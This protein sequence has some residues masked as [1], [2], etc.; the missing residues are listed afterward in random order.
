[1]TH[2]DMRTQ[3]FF[4]TFLIPYTVFFFKFSMCCRVVATALS[5]HL[6]PASPP[7][8]LLAILPTQASSSTTTILPPTSSTSSSSIQQTTKDIAKQ[9]TKKAID[10]AS[11]NNISPSTTASSASS[12]SSN[13]LPFTNVIARKLALASLGVAILSWADYEV[14]KKKRLTPLPMFYYSS[15]M[16]G[17][18]GNNNNGEMLMRMKSNKNGGNGGENDVMITTRDL[19]NII[20]PPFLPEEVTIEQYDDK[21]DD[22]EEE[23]E[24]ENVKSNNSNDN[25]RSQ[26]ESLSSNNMPFEFTPSTMKQQ[27]HDFYQSTI[28]ILPRPKTFMTVLQSWY[29]V[30]QI[31]KQ[32]EKNIKRQAIMEELIALQK[33]KK[34]R[35]LNNQ[36]HQNK[37]AL[38]SG[39]WY[40]LRNSSLN[41]LKGITTSLSSGS[42]N[43]APLG[44]ALISG[45]SR[46][47]GRAFAVEL[48]RYE[49]PLILI[50]RDEDKLASLAQDIQSAYGV[51]CIIIKADLSKH[52]TAKKIYETTKKAGLHVDILINNAGVCTTKDLVQSR[53]LDIERMMNVNVASTTVLSHLYAKDM[54]EAKRGRI[55]FVS[56][57]VGA[58][59]SGPGVATYAA[60]KAYEKS[61]AQSMGRELEKYGVGVTCLIP[62][63]VKDTSFAIRSNANEALCFKVPFYPVKAQNVASRG[64]RA[65]LHSG[66][67]EVIPGWHNRIFL[68]ILMPVLPP[69]LTSS[70]VALAW[71]PFRLPWSTN[72]YEAQILDNERIIDNA[73]KNQKIQVESNRDRLRTV[74]NNLPPRQLEIEDTKKRKKYFNNCEIDDQDFDDKIR[75]KE[76]ENK[77]DPNGDDEALNEKSVSEDVEEQSF[78]DLQDI[79]TKKDDQNV[80]DSSQQH[81]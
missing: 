41:S 9:L 40:N 18:N 69:R 4:I 81:Q 54:K 11:N 25:L 2:T 73:G 6:P 7:I 75:L 46:G 42:R 80:T 63:A 8:L 36:K 74:F 19:K 79:E 13:L 76:T 23:E 29:K 24:E 53:E 67:G 39:S 38:S 34:Q 66:D 16:N 28:P 43:V 33:I 15:L 44:Y 20:L 48:A 78:S 47:I 56:S 64:V 1:M 55:L 77:L 60:T 65:L 12:S 51:P 68:K 58:V 50:A 31:R 22:E 35:I 3:C 62:G 17:S 70:I 71:S 45:A 21:D 10:V 37:L 14:R 49:I 57:M 72:D 52:G 59:P 26:Q 5:Y 30:N 32:Q 27:I 61:L